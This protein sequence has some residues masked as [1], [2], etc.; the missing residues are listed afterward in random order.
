MQWP[1]PSPGM[2]ILQ[3]RESPKMPKLP[4]HTSFHSSHYIFLQTALL[5]NITS[6]RDTPHILRSDHIS[7]ALILLSF[8]SCHAQ[9]SLPYISVGVGPHYG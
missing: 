1:P 4:Q 3:L 2:N 9:P 5:P 7:T 6:F 8:F